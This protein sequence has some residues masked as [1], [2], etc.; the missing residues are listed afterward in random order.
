VT[1]PPRNG[2]KF[3]T[4]KP[5]QHDANACHATAVA[6]SDTSSTKLFS[7]T[8]GKGHNKKD[9]AGTGTERE[10]GDGGIALVIAGT[11]HRILTTK[12]SWRS[13]STTVLKRMFPGLS[14][15]NEPERNKLRL[16]EEGRIYALH[17]EELAPP[18]PFN[19]STLKNGIKP[20]VLAF[21]LST[22]AVR[23]VLGMYMAYTGG[24]F[25][26]F[27]GVLMLCFVGTV[28]VSTGQVLQKTFVASLFGALVGSALAFVN[29]DCV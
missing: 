3:N 25:L 28:V 19:W 4:Y 14:N 12:T 9:A 2:E 18:S 7:H 6:S 15:V 10:D 20:I 22:L 29:R 11:H 5:A 16:M 21:G 13:D 23:C 8:P 17:Y 1:A 26:L 27:V 24:T